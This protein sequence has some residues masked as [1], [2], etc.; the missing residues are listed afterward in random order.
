[1]MKEEHVMVLH[2]LS[3]CPQGLEGMTST[4]ICVRARH[5]KICNCTAH[6]FLL[7]LS[8]WGFIRIRQPSFEQIRR[9]PC[10]KGGRNIYFL[11]SFGWAV[12]RAC[13]DV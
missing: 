5:P 10:L 4:D 6:G 3:R 9:R 2:V 12:V 8:R 11:S 13:H 7:E 1:M